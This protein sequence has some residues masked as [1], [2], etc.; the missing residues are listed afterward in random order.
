MDE[1]R[2]DGGDRRGEWCWS[3]EVKTGHHNRTNVPESFV[4][5]TSGHVRRRLVVVQQYTRR[6]DTESDHE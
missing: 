3:Q 1:T 6:F 2:T 4:P 5:S